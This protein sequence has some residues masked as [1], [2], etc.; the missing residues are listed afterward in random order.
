M[1]KIIPASFSLI[2]ISGS[3]MIPQLLPV[4][5]M[6]IA[7]TTDF[8]LQPPIG[9]L[10]QPLGK[11]TTISGVI[12]Q[13]PLGAK[14]SNLDLVLSIE[15]VN[16]RPLPKPVTM[17]FHIFETAKVVQPVLGQAFRYLGYETGGFT[18]VPSVAFKLVPAVATTGYHFETVYQVLHE[19]LGQVKTKADLIR[20]NDQRVQI[21]GKYIATSKQ[22]PLQGNENMV[23]PNTGK[24]I[25]QGN[26]ATVN[27]ELADGTLVPLY[28][29]L[30]KLLNRPPQ[31]IK[32]FDGELVSI[33][34][35][36]ANQPI[37]TRSKPETS[38][39]ILRMDRIEFYQAR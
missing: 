23:A 34:G 5:A 35:S 32:E 4:S 6:P 28:S 2:A 13:V 26:Y 16:N 20:S 31:E 30:N 21:I 22:P 27:I 37:S 39:L 25:L 7:K 33:I 14:V 38:I 9:K 19:D 18:G 36:L 17:P 12:R 11:V 15:A 10:G 3:V 8:T 24:P 29:P 1:K